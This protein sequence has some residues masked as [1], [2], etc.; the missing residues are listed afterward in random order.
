MTIWQRIYLILGGGKPGD[1]EPRFD[2]GEPLPGSVSPGNQ[3]AETLKRFGLLKRDPSI[4]EFEAGFW[5]NH[6]WQWRFWRGPYRDFVAA[7]HPK[8][9]NPGWW[10]IVMS[11][12]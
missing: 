5:Y 6:V 2:V 10:E 1:P 3:L 9:K 4:P 11:E 7:H 8:L 12:W